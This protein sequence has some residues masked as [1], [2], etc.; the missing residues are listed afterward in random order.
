MLGQFVC[1]FMQALHNCV[2]VL[3]GELFNI[4]HA[5]HYKDIYDK[6]CNTLYK[7]N[8]NS[9]SQLVLILL[10]HKQE[11]VTSDLHFCKVRKWKIAIVHLFLGTN[12][13]LEILKY[14]F[15]QRPI[16]KN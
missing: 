12:I 13:G 4:L 8:I 6:Y 11:G 10:T 2:G 1:L 7:Q 15:N 5:E 3:I 14:V 9:N 16:V